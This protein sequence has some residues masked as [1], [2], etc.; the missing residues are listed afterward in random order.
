MAASAE[1]YLGQRKA[2]EPYHGYHFRILTSQGANPPGGK[3]DYV[4]NGNMIAGYALLAWPADYGRSGIMTFQ[5][6]HQGMVF[7]KNLGENTAKLAAAIT[8]YDPDKT[9][10]AVTE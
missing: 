3:Y 5:C 1:E 2:G 4:I 8:A 6:S 10:E 9:W 7:E